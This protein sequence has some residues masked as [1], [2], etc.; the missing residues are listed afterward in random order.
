LNDRH[1]YVLDDHLNPGGHIIVADL[2]YKTM[3]EAKII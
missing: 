1:F 3:T 2:L